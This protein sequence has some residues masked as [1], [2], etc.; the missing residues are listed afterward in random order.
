MD[1]AEYALGRQISYLSGFLRVILEKGNVKESIS[2]SAPL[3]VMQ[4][5][6]K[7]L[8]VPVPITDVPHKLAGGEERGPSTRVC[9][10]NRVEL[11]VQA[12]A[13]PTADGSRAVNSNQFKFFLQEPDALVAAAPT[14]QVCVPGHHVSTG[15]QPK[16]VGVVRLQLPAGTTS[17]SSSPRGC[18]GGGRAW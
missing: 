16:A 3:P 6:I 17:F 1:F 18:S 9:P 10:R 2:C 8:K 7:W 11:R 12:S 5:H 14:G 13:R 4:L 15:P